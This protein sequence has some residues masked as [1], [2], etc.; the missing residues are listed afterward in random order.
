M[1]EF[2]RKFGNPGVEYRGL[3]FWAWNG[4]LDR[5]EIKRQVN[6][7][8]DMGFGGFLF[9]QGLALLPSI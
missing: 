2:L 9:I 4:E 1:K 8:K 5:E 7:F 3:P 6:V